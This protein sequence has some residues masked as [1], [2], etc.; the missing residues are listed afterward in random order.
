MA[1]QMSEGF[2]LLSKQA[3]DGRL[4]YD[5]LADM[6][7]MEDYMLY[8]GILATIKN[9]PD[10]KTYQW[11]SSNAVE[12]E[13]GKWREFIGTDT[14]SDIEYVSSV[15][16]N[17]VEVEK[18]DDKSVD[19]DL[20]SYATQEELTTTNDNVSKI[21]TKYDDLVS[22][23]G[24]TLGLSIDDNYVMTLELKNSNNEVLDTQTLDFPIES[25][26][27]GGS[28]AD[29]KLTL[30]LQS[31]ETIDSID[32]SDIVTG[33]VENS[34][35]IAG[36]DMT[37]DITKEEL[38]TALGIDGITSGAL[39]TDLTP[40]ID[41]GG[42]KANQEFS[43]GTSLESILRALL[44]KDVNPTIAIALTEAA[45][46]KENGTTVKLTNVKITLSK[47]SCTSFDKISISDT[48][49]EIDTVPTEDLSTNTLTY[50]VTFDEEY[51]S[52]N[53]I[54]ATLSY[55]QQSGATSTV[56]ASA[57]YTFVNP[58]YCGVVSSV[59]DLTAD[60]IKAM[61]KS[62]SESKSNNYTYTTDNQLMVF[63]YPYQTDLSSIVDT[64]TGYKLTWTKTNLT[65][66]DVVY[67]IYFSNACKV[68][69][70]T[71]KFS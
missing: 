4:V 40:T 55:T 42:I 39:A 27:V 57:K 65:I 24:H 70:Y 43:E 68:T 10:K 34:F 50:N 28:Y 56:K 63:A 3:L 45:G 67:T 12:S 69:N 59:D 26:V 6:L 31:G 44:V 46:L 48:S 25:A 36:V 21:E 9:D 64:S 49:G 14:T 20:S 58:S 17:G 37:D 11:W 22:A 23:A 1:I 16:V 32:I 5:S 33:L 61:T 8:D 19:I 62:L 35:T 30:T 2:N 7:A 53:T 15:K 71:V 51:S 60:N 41:L 18:D 29:G 13:L 38:I 47:G 54:E 66:D 52:N